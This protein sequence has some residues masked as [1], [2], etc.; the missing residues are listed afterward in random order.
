MWRREAT[1]IL[2]NESERLAIVVTKLL[3]FN[4]QPN[5]A[6]QDAA[7]RVMVALLDEPHLA[8]EDRRV[9][10]AMLTPNA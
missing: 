6:T 1:G 9:I 8:D 10:S 5:A 7:R 3:R 4:L 2:L